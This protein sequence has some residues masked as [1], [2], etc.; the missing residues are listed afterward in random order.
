MSVS[1]P[2]RVGFVGLGSQGGRSYGAEDIAIVHQLLPQGPPQ[3]AQRL[4]Q[5]T[6]RVLFA[7][8]RP[9]QGDHLVAAPKT[10]PGREREVDE[11]GKS[12]RLQEKAGG[13][14]QVA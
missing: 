2:L 13:F 7:Q 3:V 6:A 5:R 14:S 8:V 9:E 12:L 10:P 1:A 4:A 11:K